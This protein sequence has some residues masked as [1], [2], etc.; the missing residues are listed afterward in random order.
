MAVLFTPSKRS[1]GS[2]VK[3]KASQGCIKRLPFAILLNRVL[4][5]LP[6]QR[7][8]PSS[9][10]S[11]EN[12]LTTGALAY[13]L[14]SPR[15]KPCQALCLALSLPSRGVPRVKVP[16]LHKAVNLGIPKKKKPINRHPKQENKAS[17]IYR[18]HS[19]R[20]ENLAPASESQG[21]RRTSQCVSCTRF[22]GANG[23]LKVRW[24]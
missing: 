2:R 20:D 8:P 22:R 18:G 7:H 21:F 5:P 15:A 17:M 4:Q 3:S 1:P 9:K 14:G 11:H 10:D 13:L 16:N 12:A 6:T 24:I 19:P 23:G